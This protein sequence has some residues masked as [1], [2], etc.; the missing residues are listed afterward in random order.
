MGLFKSKTE[1]L[2]KKYLKKLSEARKMATINR[3][4]SDRLIFEA[5]QIKK[6]MENDI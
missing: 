2:Q 6:Q 3:S 1:K 4:K 5:E